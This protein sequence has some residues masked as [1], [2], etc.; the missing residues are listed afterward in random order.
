MQLFCCWEAG[1]RAPRCPL[2]LTE[3]AGPNR[4][5]VPHSTLPIGRSGD[6]YQWTALL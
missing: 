3:Q 4:P 1:P 2:K 6:P 5:R